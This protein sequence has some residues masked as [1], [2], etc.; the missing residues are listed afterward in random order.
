MLK[1]LEAR[2]SLVVFTI[3][4]LIVLPLVYL[5]D[6]QDPVILARVFFLSFLNIIGLI[7][8]YRYRP[9]FI[10]LF[11][12]PL[13][14]S[15][16]MYLLFSLFSAT[17]ALNAPESIFEIVKLSQYF[18][19][20]IT[21][22]ILFNSG[23]KE[24]FKTYFFNFLLFSN[25]IFVAISVYQFLTINDSTDSVFLNMQGVRD[26]EAFFGNKNLFAEVLF[27]SIGL[28]IYGREYIRFKILMVVVLILQLSLIL[29]LKSS[30]IYLVLILTIGLYFLYVFV[31]RNKEFFNRNKLLLITIISS[32]LSGSII[33]II[34][35]FESLFGFR[36]LDFFE[37][38]I[39]K[40]A[41]RDHSFFD[42]ILMLRNS[43]LI[44]AD[45]FLG[46]VG[47]GN[48]SVFY[49]KYGVGGA[50]YLNQG[51]LKFQRPHND[52]L[53]ILSETGVFGLLSYIGLFLVS[54][55][56]G[57]S[58]L[59]KVKSQ[60]S[61]ILVLLLI[62]IIF[63]SF[64]SFSKERIFIHLLMLV[65]LVLMFPEGK[66]T[67]LKKS[68]LG[69]I[70]VILLF[71]ILCIYWLVNRYDAENKMYDISKLY[72]YQGTENVSESIIYLGENID[73]N[74][75]SIDRTSTPVNWYLGQAY[76]NLD[77]IDK[78]ILNFK[79]AKDRNPYHNNVLNDLAACYSLK[80][81]FER[82]E[83]LYKSIL[84]VYP[85]YSEG[86]RNLAIIL[87]QQKR[88]DEAVNV[89]SQ[90]NS[91]IEIES[92]KFKKI[93]RSIYG[94][95]IFSRLKSEKSEANKNSLKQIKDLDLFVD[96]H[97]VMMEEKVD[98]DSALTL[99]LEKQK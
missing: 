34:I 23:D 2:Y 67:F 74:Y 70:F 61:I 71:N 85:K 62:G 26:I 21:L 41:T 17:H 77:R 16:G 20:L 54:F 31:T 81:D 80:G 18:L 49:Q 88:Y 97:K 57:I 7:F 82:S 25:L 48:W 5:P 13:I 30:L 68:N 15:Y 69:A 96:I 95:V 47:V 3:L 24:I 83:L 40:G 22:V 89:L 39:V 1:K 75:L 9:D 94:Y 84:K 87:Y 79:E 56:Y 73:Q 37:D 52:F 32:L 76:F 78:A 99:F 29:L 38:G 58:D 28:L 72:F 90:I 14:L 8:L 51:L 86:L 98:Y 66:I 36:A 64:F 63:I 91:E 42:R 65:V 46:G 50:H 19:I 35:K 4:L 33:T 44:S 92:E 93:A 6:V 60:K 55:Y 27:I 11:K 12:N 10:K 45:N 59:I 53:L 43:I